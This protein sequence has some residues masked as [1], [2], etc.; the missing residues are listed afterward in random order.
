MSKYA[1][2]QLAGKQY[3]V[4]E[5]DT[6]IVNKLDQVEGENFS[7]KEVL[8]SV[9]DLDVVVGTPLV[10]GAEVTF[11]VIKQQKGDKLRV[12]TYKAKSRYRRVIGHRQRE[13]VLKV[14]KIS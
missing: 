7:T 11:S 8:L 10:A 13:T 9:N 6:L 1:V 12:A 5:G 2:I 14:V 3:R 4:Q